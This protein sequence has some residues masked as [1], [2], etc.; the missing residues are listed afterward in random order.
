MRLRL[1][2]RTCSSSLVRSLYLAPLLTDERERERDVEDVNNWKEKKKK[3]V[4]K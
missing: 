1:H 4:I 2:E 3:K